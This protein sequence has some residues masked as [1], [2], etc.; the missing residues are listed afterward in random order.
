MTELV[1]YVREDLTQGRRPELVGGGFPWIGVKNNLIKTAIIIY[2]RDM[3][4][5][6]RRLTPE[7]K[8]VF[9]ANGN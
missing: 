4:T 9:M 5:R 2:T 1:R 6:D 8:A 3:K 7:P